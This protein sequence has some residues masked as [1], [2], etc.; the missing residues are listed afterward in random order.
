ML[1]YRSDDSRIEGVV[2]TFAGISE[3][4]AAEREIEAA[5][6]YLDSIIATIRQPLIVLDEQLRVISA[7]GSFHRTFSVK[8]E[9]LVGRHL[10]AAADHLDV[11]ALHEFL[12]LDP[13]P[14]HHHQ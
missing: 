9:E 7:S 6:A 4:K 8:A 3:M 5:R 10:L 14:R 1:P 12:E 13:G 11:P 2:I